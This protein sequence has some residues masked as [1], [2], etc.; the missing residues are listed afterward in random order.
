M[1][2][3]KNQKSTDRTYRPVKIAVLDTGLGSDQRFDKVPY[4]DFVNPEHKGRVNT[5]LHG[6][7]SVD[8]IWQAYSDAVVYVGRAFKDNY[9][10][11]EPARLAEVG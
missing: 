7:V 6:A 3:S 1:K 11:T 2:M 5:T 8:L 9:D 4:R 10:S